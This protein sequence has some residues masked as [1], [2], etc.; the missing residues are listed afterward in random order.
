MASSWRTQ[1]FQPGCQGSTASSRRCRFGTLVPRKLESSSCS[2]LETGLAG[3]C[4]KSASYGTVIY[5]FQEDCFSSYQGG[6]EEERKGPF[7]T[8]Y[9]VHVTWQPSRCCSEKTKR[10]ALA[11]QSPLRSRCFSHARPLEF[12]GHATVSGGH[13]KPRVSSMWPTLWRMTSPALNIQR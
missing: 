8:T 3:H 7:A 11:E 2:S 1:E 6:D 5:G 10:Q 9:Q 4:G 13:L 12:P